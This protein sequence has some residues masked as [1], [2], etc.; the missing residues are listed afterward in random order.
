MKILYHFP[1]IDSINAYRTIFNGYKNAFV[2]LGHEFY[3]LTANDNIFDVLDEVNPDI[4]ITA[5]HFFYRKFIDYKKLKNYRDNGLFIFTKIDFWESPF[6]AQRINE[7]KSMKD[8][9]EVCD[10]IKQNLLGDVYFH[11]VEQEDHRMN[12]FKD[13]SGKDFFTIPLAAD[14]IILSG[15]FNERFEADISYI[16]TNLPAKKEFFTDYLFPLKNKYDLKLYGQD[17]TFLDRCLGWVQRGGQ[18]FNLPILKSIRKPKLALEDEA[19]IY[20]SSTISINI[21]EQHQR[22]F[23][24]DCNERTFKIPLCGG[25]EITDDVDCIRKYFVEDKEIVIAKDKKDWFNKIDYFIKNPKE[26]ITII[27]AGK[28]RVLKDHTYHNR[29]Q[30]IIDIYNDFTHKKI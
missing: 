22:D 5:S 1:N 16:G 23:G 6:V 24:G 26:R 4:F 10:L 14:K 2:D 18:Y 25:F 27:E 13:F 9:K 30:Q 15:K 19:Q 11:V 29:A 17:W 12:G 21:H 8:D 3:V 20:N 7:A 28:Q